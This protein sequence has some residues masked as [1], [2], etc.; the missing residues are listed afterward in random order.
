[1][2]RTIGRWAGDKAVLSRQ[3]V[4]SVHFLVG[5]DEG[6]WVEFYDT[7]TTTAHAA[8]AND[9]AVGIEF[10]G[11]NSDVEEL[12]DWQI[13]AGAHIVRELNQAHGIPLLFLE[14]GPRVTEFRGF[15]N[16][17]N[18]E[19]TPQYTHYD[20][21]TKAAWDRMVSGQEDDMPYTPAEL[22]KFNEWALNNIVKGDGVDGPGPKLVLIDDVKEGVLIALRSK[23]GK[24]AIREAMKDA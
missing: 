15:L 22:V 5:Q 9:Y 17:S 7:N 18:V 8:G 3:R 14:T 2:H 12:T 10:S 1:M 23:E 4:P 24:A 13:K 11:Q 6:Q 19:T 20:F 21:I 16:H